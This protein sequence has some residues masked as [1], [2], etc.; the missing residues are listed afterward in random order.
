[1]QIRYSNSDTRQRIL[2]LLDP[3]FHNVD[4]V[5][6]TNLAPGTCEVVNGADRQSIDFTDKATA[7]PGPLFVCR[8]E[9]QQRAGEKTH[10]TDSNILKFPGEV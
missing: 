6:D 3:R 1:M 9:R 5:L 10:S 2:N 8:S 7:Q 4:M